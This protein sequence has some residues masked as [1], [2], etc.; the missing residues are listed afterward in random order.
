[1]TTACPP[2]PPSSKR[3]DILDLLRGVAALMVALYH[4]SATMKG[5]VLGSWFSKGWLGVEVFF[6]ISGFVIPYSMWRAGYQIKLHYM[7]FLGKRAMR[8]YPAYMVSMFLAMAVSYGATLTP[9]YNGESINYSWTQVLLHFPLLA[10]AFGYPWIAGVFWTL[11][12]ELQYYVFIGLLFP[13]LQGNSMRVGLVFVATLGLSFLPVPPTFLLPYL[14]LFLAGVATF[15]HLRGRFPVG[16]WLGALAMSFVA[17][18]FTL[19][20]LQAAAGGLTALIIVFC[21][22][23]LPRCLLGL[24]TIS[25][26]FYLIHST[27][28]NKLINLSVRLPY[29]GLAWNAL[30]ILSA[31]LLALVSA[32]VLYYFVERPSQRWSS[33]IKFRQ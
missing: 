19:G 25:Y 17:C 13:L 3:L 2:S 16:R 26:S 21:R 23:P 27:L 31:I 15:L 30:Q 10:E 1:M 4:F 12:I 11:A 32:W 29:S 9:G 6:V 22:V 28:G 5:T 24:G 18:G 20:W 14:P 33:Q 8:L 7:R